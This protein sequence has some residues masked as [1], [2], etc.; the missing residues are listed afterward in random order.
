MARKKK[1]HRPIPRPKRPGKR[2]VTNGGKR[3]RARKTKRISG[4]V[5]RRSAIGPKHRKAR[6]AKP[7]SRH[8]RLKKK[9]LRKASPILRRRR[10]ALHKPPQKKK[11]K[12]P[13]RVKSR[14]KIRRHVKKAPPKKKKARRRLGRTLWS[15][16]EFFFLLYDNQ[17]EELDE[18]LERTL[19]DG[20]SDFILTV[21]FNYAEADGEESTINGQVE[22]EMLSGNSVEWWVAYHK[23]GRD[24]LEN[25]LG[26]ESPPGS[27]II[28]KISVPG[29]GP[30]RESSGADE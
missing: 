20:W 3:V 10:K 16:E 30:L 14:K 21:S 4:R 6:A 25:L 12:A 8:K 23:A 1:K 26:D 2:P 29:A 15:G 7:R 28:E 18:R 22:M 19:E 24:W 5:L 9:V 13:P 17:P 11:K 27:F